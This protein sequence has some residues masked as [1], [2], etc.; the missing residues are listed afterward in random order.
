MLVESRLCLRSSVCDGTCS[1]WLF[2]RI[3]L[4][5]LQKPLPEPCGHQLQIFFPTVSRRDAEGA[6]RPAPLPLHFHLPYICAN[7]ERDGCGHDRSLNSSVPWQLLGCSLEGDGAG[8]NIPPPGGPRRAPR[9]P[10]IAVVGPCRAATRTECWDSCH[11]VAQVCVLGSSALLLPLPWG[12]FPSAQER[13]SLPLTLPGQ[14]E[15]TRP[16]FPFVPLKS[17]PF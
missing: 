5:H 11:G 3:F 1:M 2:V 17:D 12:C 8:R 6:G 14:A 9:Y 13:L 4:K 16:I 15:R 7:T 10:E